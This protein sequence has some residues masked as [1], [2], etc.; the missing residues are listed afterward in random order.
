MAS[1]LVRL[2]QHRH[3]AGRGV[4]AALGFGGRHA[5][6]AVRAGF[7][8]QLAVDVVAF[9]PGD[10]FFIA[11][12]FAFVLREDLHPPAATLG[13][14]RIHAEQVAG[15]NRRLVATGAGTDFEE[16]VAAVVRDPWAA[17]C[18]AGRLPESISSS[19]ASRTS[20]TAIS[21]MSGSLSL[22]SAWAPSRSP[23]TLSSCL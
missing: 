16:H 13:V 6:H 22:S 11:A 19:L 10:D 7:E 2:G 12:V 9:D 1:L 15:E 4:D 14:T 17:A 20:S 8:L 18:V 23:C 5:L 21:R 3:G